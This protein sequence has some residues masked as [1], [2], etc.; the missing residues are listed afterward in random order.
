MVLGGVDFLNAFIRIQDCKH[1]NRGS[2]KW[3][4]VNNKKTYM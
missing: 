3:I 4:I 2:G 1:K